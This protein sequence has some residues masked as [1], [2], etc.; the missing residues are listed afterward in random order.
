MFTPCRAIVFVP[1]FIDHPDIHKV[2]QTL[3]SILILFAHPAFEKSR[4]NKVL[5]EGLDQME[6]I[7][8][9][10]LY[11]VY[12]DMDID[13]IYEQALLERHDVIVFHHPFFWYSSPAILKQWQDLVLVHGWAYGKKGQALRGKWFF[14]AM[15]TGG[16]KAFY[17]NCN[18][19][20]HYSVRQLLAPFEQAA[21]MCSMEYLPPFVVHGTHALSEQD[22]FM[23]QK[24][25]HSFLGLLRDEKINLADLKAMDYLNDYPR[26]N[27]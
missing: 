13:R 5:V 17:Q 1:V 26:E 9:H 11:Q 18:Q 21:T 3:K 25:Y 4:V 24:A 19:S 6:G 10:D 15:T 27:P 20:G 14:N 2:R 23:Y 12:P 22:I 7:T 8:F 16:P